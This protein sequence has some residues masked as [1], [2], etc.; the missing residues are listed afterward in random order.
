VCPHCGTLAHQRWFSGWAHSDQDDP[1]EPAIPSE[2]ERKKSPGVWTSDLDTIRE[3]ARFLADAQSE[4]S[5]DPRVVVEAPHDLKASLARCV[6]FSVCYA[7]RSVG[8]WIDE[9][10]V[11]PTAKVG[12]APIEHLSADVRRDF[13][14]ARSIL[15]LSPRGA[16]A[17]LRLAVEKLCIE[18]QAEGKTLD[19]KIG[20]LVKR[21]L[22]GTIARNLDIVRVIGNE[23]VHPGQ[24]D[25][26]DDRDTA[27]AL[28]D[29]VNLIADELIGRKKRREAMEAKLPP[30]K[31]KQRGGHEAQ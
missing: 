28:L 23:S 21:G 9:T 4:R 10:L 17:L 30:G 12:A 24:M 20:D 27:L 22:D 8:V 26:R 2:A 18:L 1:P 19:D 7:C 31:L 5:R 11:F 13:E 29:L 6:F 15:D 25:M 14:E 16:A 3:A